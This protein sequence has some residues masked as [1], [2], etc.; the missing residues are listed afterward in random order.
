LIDSLIEPNSRVLDIGSGDGE[1]LSR[2]IEGKNVVG[3]GIELDQDLIIH[4][5]EQGLSAIQRDIER[6]LSL[7][8]DKSFDYAILSQTLQTVKS[9]DKVLAELNRVAKK[10]IV[11]FP[12]FANYKCRLQ[13][14][15]TGKAPLTKQLPFQWY[16]TPNIHCLSLKDFDRFCRDLGIKVEKKIP[17]TKSSLVPVKIIPNL[18]AEQAVYLTSKD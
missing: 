11:S 16:D 8:K 7:Y 10:V 9:P 6:G 18:F 3:E 1:L 2:L 12:N 4:S 14:L 13:L 5:I 15:L 17:L